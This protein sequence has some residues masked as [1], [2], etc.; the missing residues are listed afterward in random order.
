[1]ILDW[2]PKEQD[3]VWNLE[4]VENLMPELYQQIGQF[5]IHYLQDITL[6]WNVLHFQVLQN[7]GLSLLSAYRSVILFQSIQQLQE[8]ILDPGVPTLLLVEW[9]F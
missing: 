7:V 3:R 1:L 8:N 5:S 9:L 4:N 2:R 6:D